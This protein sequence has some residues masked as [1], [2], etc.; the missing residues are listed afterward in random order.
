M[1]AAGLVLVMAMLEPMELQ[2]VL[3][4]ALL[5]M[6]A[7]FGLVVLEFLVKDLQAAPELPAVVHITGLVAAE[8]LAL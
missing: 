5:V 7:H 2:V 4:A 8:V 6:P 3:V 1:V